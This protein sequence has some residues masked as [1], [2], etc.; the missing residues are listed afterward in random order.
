MRFSLLRDN[1]S[2]S[3]GYNRGNWTIRGESHEIHL[4]N[5]HLD[6]IVRSINPHPM[7][8]TSQSP[9]GGQ[10]Q[11]AGESGTLPNRQQSNRLLETTVTSNKL[12]IIDDVFMDKAFQHANEALAAN[13][14]PVGCL[15]V[16]AH[17]NEVVAIGT[18][19]VNET[20]NATRHAEMNC[21]DVIVER[22]RVRG[23]DVATIFRDISVYVTV[24]PCVMCAAAL[25]E[26]LHVKR[27]VYGCKNDRFG[28]ASVFDV[29]PPD[30]TVVRGGYRADEA[31]DLLKRFYSGVNPNAPVDKVKTRKAAVNGGAVTLS[32][33]NKI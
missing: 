1:S 30:G 12:S 14:V 10:Q 3:T 26:V 15:F 31:M 17:N 6:Y 33:Q 24:E 2:A 18:N 16:T 22:C 20:R 5:N 23:E 7:S 27:V 19:T 28:G 9:S 21:I 29:R 25:Y 11:L 32:G 4:E 8:D 13:E